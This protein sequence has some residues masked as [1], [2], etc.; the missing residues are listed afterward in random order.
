MTNSNIICNIKEMDLTKLSKNVLLA[1]CEEFGITKYKSKNKS[2]LIEIIKN[3]QFKPKSTKTQ[4]EF[5]IEDD[6]SNDELIS[7]KDIPIINIDNS[8]FEELK[9]YYNNV[10]NLDKTTYQSSNDEPTPIE[11]IIDMVDKIQVDLWSRDDL[12]ILDPCCGNGNFA[13]PVLFKLLKANHTKKSILENIIEFNDINIDRLNNVKKIYCKNNYSL[14]ITN[15]DYLKHNYLKKYD[16]VM[17]N[18][19]YAKILENGKRASKNHNLIKDFIKKTLQIL[20]PNGYLMFITPDNWMSYADRNTLIEI[21]TDLQIIH[22][23]IHSAKKYFKK[24]GS[25]FTWYVI[26]N[27]KSYKNINISGMWKKT[28]YESSVISCKRKYIPLIYNNLVYSILQKTIDNTS[29]QK[30]DVKTSSDLHKYTKAE[31][32]NDNKTDKYKY[33]LIHTPSQTVYSSR[34][35]KYQEGYKVFISTTDKYKVFIDNCGMTQSIVFIQCNDEE[36][37]KKYLNILQ[38]PL[39]VFLNNIC[40]WGNFNNI[41]ILQS[42]PILEINYSGEYNEIY[43]H[44]NISNEE[45]EFI[46]HNL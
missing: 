34:P 14:N 32:I 43:T 12:S 45:I 39:Y 33:K 10:V 38:H 6:N 16:L 27:C 23:D 15:V 21:L 28:Y 7:I 37:A 22:L 24:I 31:F 40:R 35:H 19:P 8:N 5:I 4:I 42:F 17:A 1:K 20:K 41:R 9:N 30:F 29:L 11:C 3:F 18:P 46:T 2:E 13:L 25:S 44:F 26:Q 36:Q